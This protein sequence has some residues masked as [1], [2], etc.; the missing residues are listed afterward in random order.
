MTDTSKPW[1]N[2]E[3]TG[4][5]GETHQVPMKK[6]PPASPRQHAVPVR[7]SSLV[8]D[9]GT[10]DLREFLPLLRMGFL[11]ETKM[12]QNLAA[13]LRE[14]LGLGNPGGTVTVRFDEEP[15]RDIEKA[16]LREGSVLTV[17]AAVPGERESSPPGEGHFGA[18][19]ADHRAR[20]G[21]A[22]R[23]GP[24]MVSMVRLRLGEGLLEDRG[25][26]ILQKGILIEGKT[27]DAY[28]SGRDRRFFRKVRRL[29]ISGEEADPAWLGSGGPGRLC[30]WVHL[31]V[32]SP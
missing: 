3:A 7:I 18:P 17:G 11:C 25:A 16:T 8:L 22:V 4:P 13:F 30:D 28:F 20:T 10:E 23:S 32:R 29:R 14:T 12:E 31:I 19:K 24:R 2:G 15:V 21:K 6:R 5:S 27:V 1:K 9:V 26:P